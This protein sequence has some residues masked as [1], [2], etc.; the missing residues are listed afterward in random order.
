[1]SMRVV[2]LGPPGAGKG[3]QARQLA[4]EWGVPSIATGDMLRD[5]AAAGTPAGLRAKQIMDTGALVSDDVIM[6]LMGERLRA[7]DAARGF[8]LDGVP[9]TIGQ[10]EGI[11]SL[12]KELGHDLDRVVYFDVPEAELLRRLTGRR[13][14]RSC[15]TPYHVV[16]APPRVPH[17][18]DRCGG[19]LYQRDDDKEE[20]VKRRLHV[21]TTQTAPLLEYYRNR[22]RLVTV[23]AQGAV[24]AIADA[25]RRATSR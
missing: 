25:I 1:M 20:T 15:G 14:C 21:Y 23:P 4:Q 5:A 22:S 8:I 6:E 7:P 17:R 24:D 12:L 13:L 18:C 10:A 16:S 9:R 19:E 2:F 11:E 3:T